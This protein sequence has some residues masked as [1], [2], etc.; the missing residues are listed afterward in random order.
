MGTRDRG[1]E[2][3]MFSTVWKLRERPRRASQDEEES[4]P[5]LLG[6]IGSDP[7]LSVPFSGFTQFGRE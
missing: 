3:F 2:S 6:K 7:I 1:V 5:D 4:N